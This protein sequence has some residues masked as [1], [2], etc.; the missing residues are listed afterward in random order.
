MLTA[1]PIEEFAA[2][3]VLKSSPL[4][5]GSAAVLTGLIADGVLELV[6]NVFLEK[7]EQHGELL[8]TS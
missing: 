4:S 3:L 2:K 5:G 6:I 1:L 8:K 7:N